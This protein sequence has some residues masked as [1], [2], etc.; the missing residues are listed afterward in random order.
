MPNDYFRAQADWRRQKAGEYPD[1][2]R[3]ARSAEAL[4][5]LAEYVE[6]GE[7][8]RLVEG[9]TP[10]LFVG[11]SLGG[12]E[13]H[14]AVVRYGFDYPVNADANPTQHVEFL[15]G[16]QVLCMID[17]YQY[18]ADGNDPTGELY[19]FEVDAARDGVHLPHTYF[20]RRSGSMEHELEGVVADY[21]HD[22]GD[23]PPQ[24]EDVVR[25]TSIRG[26]KA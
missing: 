15:E 7:A 4:D 2:A 6:S 18:A 19:G 16:L 20:E 22:G 9:L 1:D 23:G 25:L 11:M 12:E 24:G 5:S 13:T 10:H 3:N 14:R 21:R 8:D 26:G 17:A